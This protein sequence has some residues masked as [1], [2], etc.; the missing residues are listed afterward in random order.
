MAAMAAG[1]GLKVSTFVADVTPPMGAPLCYGLVPV[2][3]EV[4]DKLWARGVVLRPAGEKPIVLCAVDWLGIGNGSRDR[5]RAVLAKAAGTV[6]ERVALHTVHQ[7]DAPGDDLSAHAFLPAGVPLCDVDFA[8]GAAGRVAA[9]VKTSKAVAVTAV[10]GGAAAVSEV[11]SNRRILG[12][13]GKV[14]FGRMTSCRNSP[15]CAAPEGVI[16]PLMRSVSFWAGEKRVATLSYYATHPMSYYGKG[17][18][19]SDFVGQARDLQTDTFQ[20]HF[21]GAAGNIGAGKYNDGAPANRAV[22]RDRM[23]DAMRRAKAAEKPVSLDAVRWVSE[24]VAMPLRVG[25][26]FGEDEL[27]AAIADAKLDSKQRANHARY[28]AFLRM[29]KGGRKIDLTALRL[30]SFS[31]LHM[32]G[33]LFVEYQLAAADMRK[34]E[35]VATAAYGDYG[36][37]YI[38]TARAYDEGGYETSAVSRVGPA[39]EDVLMGAMRKVLG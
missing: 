3:S 36:P 30:G 20:V 13:D 10:T 23:A 29:T 15:Q 12:P 8:R 11:A 1:R 26:G 31:V 6:P 24:S 35:L 9:A 37:M 14:A 39:V 5:W 16:D 34:G 7:H 38:G 18:V 27:V 28:L 32:P 17:G 25:K 21:T 19:S 2:A 33:E 4:V 22:L